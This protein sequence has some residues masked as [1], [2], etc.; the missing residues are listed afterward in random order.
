MPSP[1]KLASASE[2]ELDVGETADGGSAGYVGFVTLSSGEPAVL[3]VP[4]Y[5]QDPSRAA[6]R[7]L[8]AAKGEGY[9]KALRYDTATDAMLM[10]RLGPRLESTHADP[11]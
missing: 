10:E 6:S 2:W 1:A 5:G 3:K 7:V 8:L 4:I 11:R 9:V